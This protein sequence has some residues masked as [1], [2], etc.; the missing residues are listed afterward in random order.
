M[1]DPPRD[2]TTGSIE[3][4]SER[5]LLAIDTS[6]DQAGI[7]LT[8][9][10][11]VA[12]LGWSAG[13]T[14]TVTVLPEIERMLRT[15]G[16][17]RR[18]LG[19]VAVATGPGTFTGLRVGLSL[20]KGLVIALDVALLGVPTL[21]IAAAPY[22]AAGTSV[23]VALAAGR[24]RIVWASYGPTA[25]E[26]GRHHGPVN[27]RIDDLAAWLRDRPDLLVT[28]ELDPAARS[29]LLAAGHRRIEDMLLS[30]RR[31]AA[32]AAIAWRR[33]QTGDVDDSVTL[34]PF[35]LHAARPMSSHP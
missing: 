17:D 30:R 35:Y 2:N 3:R 6:T 13:R 20:A 28:G 27:T 18:M 24:S 15:A 29:V 10:E 23:V 19:A 7:A 12:E 14:Q 33:W 32:L 11:R 16:I 5:W 1:V 31:P 21:D 8:D 34:E 26:F 9:G 22:A 25:G 4:D